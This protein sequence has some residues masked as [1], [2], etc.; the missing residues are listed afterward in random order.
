MSAVKAARAAKAAADRR[1]TWYVTTSRVGR[2]AREKRERRTGAADC[3]GLWPRNDNKGG[4]HEKTHE[5]D[6]AAES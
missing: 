3:S 5:R 1:Q 6:P 4:N 2:E